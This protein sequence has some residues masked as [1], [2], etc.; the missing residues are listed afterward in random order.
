MSGIVFVPSPRRQQGRKKRPCWRCGLVVFLLCAGR[1][2]A[3]VVKG[4]FQKV[5]TERD[6]LTLSVRGAERTF[7]LSSDVKVTGLI[8]I[9]LKDGLDSRLFR[10]PGVYLALK[11]ERR[12]GR[13]VVA[14]IVLL[15]RG[16]SPVH[17]KP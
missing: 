12:D 13:E 7:S 6:A 17:S 4:V 3:D 9:P 11:T 5:S 14:E 2:P 16:A 8:D 15:R 10:R 1:A